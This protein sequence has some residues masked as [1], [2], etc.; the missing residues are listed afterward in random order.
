ML[1]PPLSLRHSPP[2]ETVPC[3]LSRPASAGAREGIPQR[4]RRPHRARGDV[5]RGDA[6]MQCRACE[7]ISACL[8]RIRLRHSAECELEH[9]CDAGMSSKG[10]FPVNLAPEKSMHPGLTL[11]SPVTGESP[12][13]RPAAHNHAT[14]RRHRTSHQVSLTL[15]LPV[16]LSV[17]LSASLSVSRSR[18]LPRL[19]T[20]LPGVTWHV[21]SSRC[22]AV[23][24]LLG[25]ARV[26]RC[27][28]TAGFRV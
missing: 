2:A 4:H 26:R 9:D 11:C 8:K 21:A 28:E 22:E 23:G 13:T 19:E 25:L 17:A 5:E 1:C 15:S 10:P 20:S 16:S 3:A 7:H 27:A 18:S 24:C 14:A 12:R 6:R